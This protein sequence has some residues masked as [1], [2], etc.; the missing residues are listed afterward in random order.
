MPGKIRRESIKFTDHNKEKQSDPNKSRRAVHSDTDARTL[1]RTFS[2]VAEYE[3][4]S[5]I[6]INTEQLLTPIMQLHLLYRLNN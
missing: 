6:C 3:H 2:S 4:F 5:D 1:L